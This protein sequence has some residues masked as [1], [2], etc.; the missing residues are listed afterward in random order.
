M[1]YEMGRKISGKCN[2]TRKT[3]G[4][5][6]VTASSWEIYEQIYSVIRMKNCGLAFEEQPRIE[7]AIRSSL[8]MYQS[9]SFI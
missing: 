3:V 7:F 5:L 6:A 2:V 8:V 9:V 4:C 1:V